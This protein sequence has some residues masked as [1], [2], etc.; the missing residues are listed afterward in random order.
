MTNLPDTALGWLLYEG[1]SIVTEERS[2]QRQKPAKERLSSLL[3]RLLPKSKHYR[4]YLHN[5]PRPQEPIPRGGSG[6]FEASISGEDTGG[7]CLSV[8]VA[9][10]GSG[11]AT[12]HQQYDPDLGNG[13]T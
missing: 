7:D 6:F 10:L 9:G 11:T 13:E 12:P 3:L 5:P 8:E 1:S 4:K 2:G